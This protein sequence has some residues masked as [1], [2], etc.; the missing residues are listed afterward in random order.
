[1]DEA[2]LACRQE[3]RKKWWGYVPDHFRDRFVSP[4]EQY[5]ERVGQPFVVLGRDF[6]AEANLDE[7]ELLYRIRFPDGTEIT[8]WG[9]EVCVDSLNHKPEPQ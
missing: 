8:A 7:H 1:V 2:T 9:E 6:D 3:S 5:A 4:F